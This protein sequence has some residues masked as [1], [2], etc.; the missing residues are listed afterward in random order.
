MAAWFRD[1]GCPVAVVAN[2]MDKLKKSEIAPN[3]QQIRDT[4]SLTE[5]DMLLPFSAE[6]GTGLEELRRCLGAYIP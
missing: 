4:L 1:T 5:S 3:L 6:K 2:K